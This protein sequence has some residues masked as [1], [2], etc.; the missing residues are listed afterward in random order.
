[1]LFGLSNALASFYDYIN[2]I[3]AKKLSFFI[4]VYLINIFIYIKDLN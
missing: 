3:W 1:M 4:I 2:K